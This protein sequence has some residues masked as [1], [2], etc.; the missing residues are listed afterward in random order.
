MGKG[1]IT[2]SSYSEN[3]KYED[4]ATQEQLIE[5]APEEDA[6]LHCYSGINTMIL[7]Q[8]YQNLTDE[9]RYQEKINI[10]SSAIGCS[11]YPL[12]K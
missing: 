7:M 4:L 2:L 9:D 5:E 12:L 6:L 3:R 11:L 1:Q 8:L 10:L